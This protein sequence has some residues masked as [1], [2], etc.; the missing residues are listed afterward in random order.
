MAAVALV[1]APALPAVGQQVLETI[2]ESGRTIISESFRA[3]SMHPRLMATDAERRLV[4]VHDGEEPN[5]VM[6]F[7]LVTGERL[8]VISVS[9]GD[10]PGE[11]RGPIQR[12]VLAEHGG[13]YVAGAGRMLEFDAGHRFLSSWSG[14]L[15]GGVAC[16]LGGEPAGLTAQGLARR[17]T[18]GT[19][20]TVGQWK[21]EEV[22][23]VIG[24]TL[25]CRGDD[26][27]V[28]KVADTGP[29]TVHLIRDGAPAD[30]IPIP[31]GH[32]DGPELW[33]GLVGSSL[34]IQPRDD[35]DLLGMVID[36][37]TG[38]HALI[39]NKG[40]SDDL[41]AGIYQDSAVVVHKGVT[42]IRRPDGITVVTVAATGSEVSLV[43]LRR[44][45]GDPCSGMLPTVN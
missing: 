24:A 18:D 6:A 2:P 25:V 15:F 43:P 22:D 29:P 4:Y 10:G 40:R 9:A 42:R 37:L 12:I 34:L 16:E 17:G 36:P 13:L 33:M 28:M 1:L 7:S 14:P 23:D 35:P 5:G 21:M 38:C 45:S 27:Y 8:A 31:A 19:N 44:V 41:V 3:I 30:D 26:A 32:L 11:L 20:E 39:R